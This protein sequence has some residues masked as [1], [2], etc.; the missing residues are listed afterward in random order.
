MAVE[1]VGQVLVVERDG[2]L[3]GMVSAVD[4]A[5]HFAALAGYT[6]T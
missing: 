6:I 1:G 4:I 3:L 2:R 5:R